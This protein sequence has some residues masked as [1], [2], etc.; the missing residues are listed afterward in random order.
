MVGIVGSHGPASSQPGQRSWRSTHAAAA[1]LAGGPMAWGDSASCGCRQAQP[2]TASIC[3]GLCSHSPAQAHSRQLSCLSATPSQAA[4]RPDGGVR[5]ASLCTHAPQ[6]TC[7]GVERRARAEGEVRVM[8]R[9]Q[10]PRRAA[11]HRTDPAHHL[12]RPLALAHP[13]P[14]LTGPPLVTAR[15]SR[16]AG[17]PRR[18]TRRCAGVE[19]RPDARARL[20]PLAG[21]TG[22]RA[23]SHHTRARGGHV[24]RAATGGGA[25]CAVGGP[26]GAAVGAAEGRLA[27]GLSSCTTTTTTNTTAA[28]R[29]AEAA[30]S[31]AEDT[32]VRVDAAILHLLVQGA[33]ALA[34]A[35]LAVRRV[36][37]ARLGCR[38]RR[39]RAEAAGD[40]ACHV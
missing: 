33:L 40:R 19:L 7:A 2:H 27:C 5:S 4:G 11:A 3:T 30:R 23:L 16:A 15:T 38:L 12:R 34:G 20:S 39:G 9:P 8:G 22:R 26:V 31:R 13:A 35:A 17:L 10:P 1:A 24:G 29:R 18:A 25:R 14:V 21:A 36:V 6:L 28:L 37:L 32:E